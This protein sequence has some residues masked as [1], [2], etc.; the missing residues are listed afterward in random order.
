MLSNYGAKVTIV[1]FLDRMVPTEDE[2]VSKELARHYKRLGVEVLTSTRVEAVEESG[3]RVRATV[4]GP[5]GASRTLEADRLLQAIGFAPNTEGYGLEAAGIK[6][7][8]R[9]AIDV[10]ARGRTGTP[11]IYAIGDVTAKLM[12]A[13]TAEAMGIIAAETIA[14]AE[15]QEID[16]RMIPRATYCQP[17]IA[18]FGYTE[19]QARE[20]GFDVQVAKFPIMA[21]GKAHGLGD[22]RGFVKV[23]SD[24]K[25]GELLGAHMIGRR[26]PSCFRSSP[27]PSSGT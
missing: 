15:T 26:S 20:A 12:L 1:E 16:F 11:G 2:E 14:G 17:Q 13:H 5:D 4:T 9:G 19:A 24:G 10:D 18:S 25:Y 6:L 8:E 22:T 7:T 21:N 3:G 27:W 23:L